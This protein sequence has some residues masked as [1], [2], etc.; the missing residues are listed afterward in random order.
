MASVPPGARVA[1]PGKLVGERRARS[2]TVPSR[3]APARFAQGPLA[4]LAST[5]RLRVG[6]WPPRPPP[7]HPALGV[8]T[9]AACL[10]PSR[11]ACESLRIAPSDHG[12]AEAPGPSLPLVSTKRVAAGREAVHQLVQD[13]RRPGKLSKVRSSRN[14]SRRKVAGS[15]P[16]IRVPV[17]DA[18]VASKAARVPVGTRLV[19]R[20]GEAAVT[21]AQEALR[22]CRRPPRRPSTAPPCAQTV[23]QL[24]HERRPPAAA[25]R[26]KDGMRDGDASM[27][28]QGGGVI[29]GARR[30]TFVA[31]TPR[32]RNARAKTRP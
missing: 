28:R 11:A 31:W 25:S 32:W 13:R 19:R 5:G 24:M 2:G 30:S 15:P 1:H 27:P 14:S 7:V 17:E 8:P 20:N 23:A 6:I 12:A 10:Q 26:Q 3:R 4:S 29:G 21:C 9:T 16:A 18:N 22:R